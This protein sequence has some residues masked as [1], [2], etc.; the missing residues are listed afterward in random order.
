M[1]VLSEI[2]TTRF[3]S[4]IAWKFKNEEVRK[5][6]LRHERKR[7]CIDNICEQLVKVGLMSPKID[8]LKNIVLVVDSIAMAFCKNALNHHIE[9]HIS[10]A[11]RI[12]REHE[13]T[14]E[15]DAIEELR[16]CVVEVDRFTGK[17]RPFMSDDKDDA[18][19]SQKSVS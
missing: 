2:V 17:I 18:N 10:N 11:E 8:N 19:G 4:W 13:S 14:K 6:L 16:E 9:K 15:K 5:F 1:S 7:V 12:R 3:D